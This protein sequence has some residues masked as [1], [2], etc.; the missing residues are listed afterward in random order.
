[1][2]NVSIAFLFVILLHLT[3]ANNYK[4]VI[5][6]DELDINPSENNA[7]IVI[8]SAKWEFISPH[9]IDELTAEEKEKFYAIKNQTEF[10]KSECDGKYRCQRKMESNIVN[11]KILQ[12][13]VIY[14]DSRYCPHPIFIEKHMTN[15]TNSQNIEQIAQDMEMYWNRSNY[16]YTDKMS[17]FTGPTTYHVDPENPTEFCMSSEPVTGYLCRAGTAIIREICILRLVSIMGK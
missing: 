17:L 5:D 2:F 16:Q 3:R 12:F 14:D 11:K 13:K 6:G 10:L 1:M 8:Q 15:Q 7:I 9:T 4:T